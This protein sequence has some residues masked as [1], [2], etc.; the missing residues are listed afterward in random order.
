METKFISAIQGSI[1]EGCLSM[2]RKLTAIIDEASLKLF[3]S[4]L[5][6]LDHISL[7]LLLCWECTAIVNKVSKFIAQIRTAHNKLV[8]YMLH[9]N[10]ELPCLSR[11][12]KVVPETTDTY[13]VLSRNV[14]DT[15]PLA[16][17]KVEEDGDNLNADEAS[18]DEYFEEDIKVDTTL[19][20]I[21]HETPPCKVKPKRNK[22]RSEEHFNKSDDEPL[23]KKDEEEKPAVHCKAEQRKKKYHKKSDKKSRSR[24]EKPSGVVQNYK[25]EKILQRLNVDGN[26]LEMVVLS[27]EEVEEERKRALETDSF[28]RLLYKCYDCVLGFNH[29]FKLENH[30]KKHSPE[31]GA[32]VC[33]VCKVRC[34]HSPA[35]CAHKRRHRVKWRC[36]VCGAAWSRASVAAD[37]VAREHGAPM[38]T[39][40]CSVCGHRA[41]TLNKL[42]SHMKRHAERQ[43]CGQCDKTFADRSSLRTHLFIH[44]GSKEFSCPRCG[45]AFLFKRAM[46]LHQLTHEASAQLYCHQC[47][48][49]FKNQISYKQHLLY[50]LKHVDPAKLKY[51]C[52]LCDKK[53]VKAKRLEEHNLA[54]HL[55]VTPVNCTV[56]G[57]N[58]ACSSRAVLRTHTRTLHRA[59]R[60][61]RDHVCHVCGKTYTS[62][63]ALGGHLRAHTGSRPL[64]CARC[65]AAFGYEAA[66][67]NHTRLVHLKHKGGQ[68]AGEVQPPGPE[69]RSAGLTEWI[70]NPTP[71]PPDTLQQVS[72]PSISS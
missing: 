34:K 18:G 21:K 45:K 8:N 37:H 15:Q 42:R 55:K 54:V 17:I 59:V 16:F 33:D 60:A 23:L 38:P 1:C 2:D 51:A 20:P 12:S 47:D 7:P 50:S 11:L 27:W 56:P 58:F 39:H 65:P 26:Q 71:V 52:Q 36:T 46:E 28:K 4:F 53:F 41:P 67:Y 31:S 5:G 25:V 3:C 9:Q 61:R 63:V 66:L 44:N 14:P 68:G 43:R 69:V 22:T 6:D 64:R 30:M 72:E 32:E 57:C 19:D 13:E 29:R 48:M 35:L 70:S 49:N 62:K 10:K 40:L 24:R